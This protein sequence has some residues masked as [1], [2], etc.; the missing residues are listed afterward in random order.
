MRLSHGKIN[1]ML[2]IHLRPNRKEIKMEDQEIK[3][4]DK[5]KLMT[6]EDEEDPILKEEPKS[7]SSDTLQH[8][9][10]KREVKKSEVI[11]QNTERK[12]LIEK[13]A[14]QARKDRNEK[15]VS[16]PVCKFRSRNDEF[17]FN[18][19]IAMTICPRCGVAFIQAI[20]R[21][22]IMQQIEMQKSGLVIP[23]VQSAP[24]KRN[25]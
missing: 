14:D 19:Q 18:K 3:V 24:I 2:K 11:K 9:F 4:I 20:N 22:G 17:L 13:L 5:R 7:F 1:S 10:P 12:M 16:C 6:E 23:Q 25:G 15:Q 21:L 8:D